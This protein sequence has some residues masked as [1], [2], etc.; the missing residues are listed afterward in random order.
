MD[1]ISGADFTNSLYLFTKLQIDSALGHHEQVSDLPAN[2][3]FPPDWNLVNLLIKRGVSISA[4]AKAC[5]SLSVSFISVPK[6]ASK[7]LNDLI[8]LRQNVIWMKLSGCEVG[9]E[10]MSALK[11]FAGLTRL[12]LDN[13]EVTDNGLV[14]ISSLSELVSLNLK[15]VP[16]TAEG[17]MKLSKLTKLH[18]LYLYKT[19]T[20]ESD[21]LK[22]QTVFKNTRIDFGDYLVP[23]LITDTTLVKPAKK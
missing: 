11:E 16:V 14:V 1:Y 18:D 15:G 2:E 10:S 19:K 21:H 22:L 4:V 17:V 20:A 3:T 13:T 5:N 12:S 8:P 23:T 6:N 9:D 7:L